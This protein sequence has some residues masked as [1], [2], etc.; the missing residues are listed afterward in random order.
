MAKMGSKGINENR[1]E[2]L[3]L[4]RLNGPRYNKSE[5]RPKGFI[6]LTRFTGLKSL[7]FTGAQRAQM[8]LKRAQI[9]RLKFLYVK[10]KW[11]KKICRL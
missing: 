10:K 1:G 9:P 2:L 6:K 11:V 4:K 8:G 7:R 3:S 5:N